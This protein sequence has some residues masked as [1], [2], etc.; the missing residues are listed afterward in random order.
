MHNQP[1]LLHL[2]CLHS[3]NTFVAAAAVGHF[4]VL[5]SFAAVEEAPLKVLQFSLMQMS[6][7]G[8][9]SIKIQ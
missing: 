8:V 7:P 1:F 9:V 6:G 3:C 5:Q 4:L 2:K